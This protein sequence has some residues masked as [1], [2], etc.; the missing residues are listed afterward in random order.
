MKNIFKVLLFFLVAA[1]LTQN[2]FAVKDPVEPPK[3]GPVIMVIG[4]QPGMPRAIVT[5]D[6]VT[7]IAAAKFDYFESMVNISEL[8]I[9]NKVRPDYATFLL[10]GIDKPS[11][12]WMWNG[13][14]SLKSTGINSTPI[15]GDDGVQ[16]RVRYYLD[17]KDQVKAFTM[18]SVSKSRGSNNTQKTAWYGNNGQRILYRDQVTDNAAKRNTFTETIYMNDG[19]G[20]V[21]SIR[22]FVYP[23]GD[24]KAKKAKVY[25]EWFYG[26][27]EPI[28]SFKGTQANAAL[29]ED[30][31]Y[32]MERDNNQYVG[33]IT[34]FSGEKDYS[35][36]EKGAPLSDINAVVNKVGQDFERYGIDPVTNIPSK[37]LKIEVK[38]KPFNQNNEGEIRIHVNG[39]L[40]PV[41]IFDVKKVGNNIGDY[42]AVPRSLSSG[43][44]KV[45]NK[46]GDSFEILFENF[47]IVVN[48]DLTKPFSGCASVYSEYR[49]ANGP[50]TVNKNWKNL[51]VGQKVGQFITVRFKQDGTKDNM[52]VLDRLEDQVKS[53][54]TDRTGQ[55]TDMATTLR[56]GETVSRFT[57][58]ENNIIT[59]YIGKGGELIAIEVAHYADE[60]RVVLFNAFYPG[61]RWNITTPFT[62][63]DGVEIQKG[64]VYVQNAQEAYSFFQPEMKMFYG[65]NG[66]RVKDRRILSEEVKHHTQAI[67]S[68]NNEGMVIYFVV[69]YLPDYKTIFSAELVDG[70]TGEYKITSPR[71]DIKSIRGKGSYGP[72]VSKAE[73]AYDVFELEMNVATVEWATLP[74]KNVTV[75]RNVITQD[76][77]F[78]DVVVGRDADN[79]I[80]HVEA[81]DASNVVDPKL[82]LLAKKKQVQTNLDNYTEYSL[83]MGIPGKGQQND[84]S[85]TIDNEY[86][87]SLKTPAEVINAFGIETSKRP[88]VETDFHGEYTT[89][90]LRFQENKGSVIMGVN[91]DNEVVSVSINYKASSQADRRHFNATS[92]TGPL[93]ST[94]AEGHETM[95]VESKYIKWNLTRTE[96]SDMF[97]IVRVLRSMRHVLDKIMPGFLDYIKTEFV[98]SDTKVEEFIKKPID[99]IL[100]DDVYIKDLVN[101]GELIA[102][103]NNQKSKTKAME[104][105]QK[106]MD[107]F[108]QTQDEIRFRSRPD[109]LSDNGLVVRVIYLM[110]L[111]DEIT[112][113]YNVRLA[114]T[115]L[116]KYPPDKLNEYTSLLL[117]PET[118]IQ[119]IEKA[120]ES[121]IRGELISRGGLSQILN[122]VGLHSDAYETIVTNLKNI[123]NESLPGWWDNFT[124]A[125]QEIDPNYSPLDYATIA[126]SELLKQIP[127]LIS[128]NAAKLKEMLRNRETKTEG[129]VTLYNIYRALRTPAGE[130]MFTDHVRYIAEIMQIVSDNKINYVPSRESPAYTN[131]I[132][133]IQA[134]NKGEKELDIKFFMDRQDGIIRV[135]AL[136]DYVAE[137][138]SEI[139]GA[140]M[141]SAALAERS[142]SYGKSSFEINFAAMD[143]M[144]AVDDIRYRKASEL[145]IDGDIEKLIEEAKARGRDAAARDAKKL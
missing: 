34:Y 94:D 38:D 69:N 83:G 40:E 121:L 55:I 98:T 28:A 9:K 61:G 116:A 135:E 130:K 136:K 26:A 24:K 18:G 37:G 67:V 47:Y 103:L 36:G 71:R 60:V 119:D 90:Y 115:Q 73:R 11:T 100:S 21:G 41:E 59:A 62:P 66:R 31:P 104:T 140:Y 3:T 107:K 86:L 106:L 77:K 126:P 138:P 50:V 14:E 81:Y 88:E 10:E 75:E 19:S 42:S 87:N 29:N 139:L 101:N 102:L 79:K 89:K 54:P 122:Y 78:V 13:R 91:N 65:D 57:T 132:K 105:S 92:K 134:V 46:Q 15:S 43:A 76:G 39:S 110:H 114:T 95:Y 8:Y 33:V 1:G 85:S 120:Q 52:V 48:F 44:T 113:M 35:Y 53:V 80:N 97:N 16:Y 131:A 129:V 124:K 74:S 133:E 32:L 6:N 137:N 56:N 12:D 141:I 64:A 125:M 63:K 96:R 25:V 112:G 68:T 49:G 144:I 27:E 82:I 108:Y 4:N 5:L 51:W 20:R 7:V 127:E 142:I 45:M 118:T 109:D 123:V 117:R 30:R 84:F 111:L 128:D 2:A 22:K 99:Q 145:R 72:Y 23:W 143:L 58:P 17:E 70:K 93:Y